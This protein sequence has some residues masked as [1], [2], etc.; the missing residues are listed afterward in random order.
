MR[1]RTVDKAGVVSVQQCFTDDFQ[2]VPF[3]DGR[4]AYCGRPFHKNHNKNLFCSD[5]CALNRLREQKAE[6]QRK[7]RLLVKRK[8]LILQENQKYGLGSYGTSNCAHR[9]KSFEEEKESIH[10]EMKR[11]KLKKMW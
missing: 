8:I 5:D 7:R 9:K 4:C 6:Y 1:S 2:L 10:N 11:L 3:F